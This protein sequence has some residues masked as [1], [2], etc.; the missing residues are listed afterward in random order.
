[1]ALRLMKGVNVRDPVGFARTAWIL[2]D[3]A[4]SGFSTVLITLVVAYVERVVFAA[5]GWG[6]SG[7]VVWAWTLAAAMLLSAVLTPWAAAW[8]DRR[9]AHERALLASTLV[10]AGGLIALALA[11]PVARLAVVL[12]IVAAC[13][14]F[15][16]AQV[17]TGSLLP[18][19]AGERDADRLSAYGFAA[20]YAGGAIALV[21]ATAVVAAHDRL[22][23]TAAGGL[24]LAFA[25]TAAWWIAFSLPAMIARF[26]DG[27]RARHAATSGRELLAFARSLAQPD[28]IDVPRHLG[29]VL[30]GTMLAL[31]AVQTA[32]AQFSS[33]ALER[34]DLDGPALVRLVLLVQAV[35]LP[36]ALGCG[37]LSTR[38]GRW[39]T[40]TVCLGGWVAV[41][42]LAWFIETPA[43]LYGLAV[44]LALVLGGIQS[45]L[46][47][48]IAA[49]APE[50]RSGVTFGLMQVGS[51]LS[52]FVASLAFGAVQ[53]I[54]HDPRN[55]LAVLLVQLMA[56]WWFLRR[57]R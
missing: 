4:A 47:A 25:L 15:D 12:A 5:G 44:L 40:A 26:G 30:L 1:M 49:L 42:V 37:W 22:G 41:L 11:P 2:L 48:S 9:H 33:L 28:A 45:V 13:V 3:W 8:A 10:G 38:F 36:G 17:F 53:A 24:R 52:G 16:L 18:R 46:R 14:G 31:G 54:T 51:K 39:P 20:G 27:E 7:G 50:G 34:F 43:Q 55:G 6:L 57:L 56:G 23:L 32:I 19:I 21:A 29:G 35:A